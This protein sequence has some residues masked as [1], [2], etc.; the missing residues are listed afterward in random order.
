[1]KVPL[2][3]K[4]YGTIKQ[5]NQSFSDNKSAFQRVVLAP[6]PHP[7]AQAI[8]FVTGQQ[9]VLGGEPLTI[10]FIPTTPIPTS[11]FLLLYPE[12]VLVK[13]DMPV[14]DGFKFIISLGVIHPGVPSRA[15]EP[16]E[17]AVAPSLWTP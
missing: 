1:M 8:G 6:F 7:G 4:I 17:R 16:T 15:I 14:A 10:V 9:R 11:G 3:N 5:V 13:L 12:S 2:L